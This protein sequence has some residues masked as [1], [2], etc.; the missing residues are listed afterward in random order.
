MAFLLHNQH[1]EL[2]SL[3]EHVKSRRSDR[4]MEIRN[5]SKDQCPLPKSDS[6]NSLTNNEVP[7]GYGGRKFHVKDSTLTGRLR[8]GGKGWESGCVISHKYK[9][10]YIHVLKS[11]G[12]AIKMFLKEGLCGTS[13]AKDPCPGGE[14]FF[15]VKSKCSD[16]LKKF[17]NYFAWSL[18]RN[19]FSRMFSAY[20][21]S[22]SYAEHSIEFE[23]FVLD[24]KKRIKFT[25]MSNSHYLPQNRFLFD[26][27]DCPFFDFVGRLENMEEDMTYILDKIG[28][29]ELLK[30]F[31]SQNRIVAKKNTW[32]ETKRKKLHGGDLQAAYKNEAVRRA[33]A[34]EFHDDFRL[35]GYDPSVI[36]RS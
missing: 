1:S 24:K 15:S 27:N 36:P 9:F 4:L 22:L 34:K 16:M 17:P 13:K 21:M 11:G 29:P 7:I 32:G 28:S 18:G 5:H 14:P 25:K 31:K 6:L 26:G 30:L 10:I 2:I 3:N 33:V 12:T 35:L 20:S 23:S 19:P 8:F